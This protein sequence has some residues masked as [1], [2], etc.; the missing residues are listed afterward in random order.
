M[1]VALNVRDRLTA[2]TSC[3]SLEPQTLLSVKNWAKQ[4][5]R[6]SQTFF[7]YFNIHLFC[8]CTDH[9]DMSPQTRNRQHWKIQH[10]CACH[11]CTYLIVH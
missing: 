4:I 5:V 2:G 8:R 1:K 9:H 7:N 6:C 3:S 11:K 10:G